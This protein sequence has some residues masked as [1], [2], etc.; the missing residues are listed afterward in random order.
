MSDELVRVYS[1]P[2]AFDVE[3]MKGRL[4]A[5]G[6]QVMKKGG[7]E[8]PYPSGPGY[9]WVL[10]ADEARAREVVEAMNSGAYAVNDEDVL[11]A[12]EDSPATD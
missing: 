3:L 5:E 10:A 9:L 12:A 1:S 11:E 4:E 6:I 2:D 8:G 7:D